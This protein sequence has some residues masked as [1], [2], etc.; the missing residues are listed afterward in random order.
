VALFICGVFLWQAAFGPLFVR[1]K[2]ITIIDI[3]EFPE[4]GANSSCGL[5]RRQDNNTF[6][7]F[8][9][10]DLQSY[11]V[12]VNLGYQLILMLCDFQWTTVLPDLSEDYTFPQSD[13]H[14]RQNSVYHDLE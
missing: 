3:E 4:S 12:C 13:E 10:V 5:S 11:P 7:V 8:M 9:R 14:L 1:L 2:A 6:T